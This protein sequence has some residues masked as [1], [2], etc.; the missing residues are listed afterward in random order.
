[1]VLRAFRLHRSITTHFAHRPVTTRA[2]REKYA[3]LRLD[4]ERWEALEGL[5]GFL[6]PFNVLTTAAEGSAYP[7]ISMVLPGYNELLD[8]LERRARSEA[9]PLLTQLIS[10]ALPSLKKYYSG[11]TD[12]LVI[13]TFLDPAFA[14]LRWTPTSAA[15]G[16]GGASDDEVERYLR[17]DVVQTSSPLEYWRDAK[18]MDTLKEMARDYL[19]TPATTAASE[20]VF[21]KGRNLITWQRHRESTDTVRSCATLK[22]WYETHLGQHPGDGAVSVT[23]PTPNLCV[24]GEGDE[25]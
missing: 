6:A 7:T 14:I 22:S 5:K 8:T 17:D 4:D 12:E 16:G 2:E 10:A 19:A 23:G 13:C 9:S 21:S 25:E 15:A 18:N 24:E 1:M 11:C 3:T 20:C